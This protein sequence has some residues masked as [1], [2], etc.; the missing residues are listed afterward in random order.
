MFKKKNTFFFYQIFTLRKFFFK[1]EKKEESKSNSLIFHEDT[2]ELSAILMAEVP[3]CGDS[4]SILSSL[5]SGSASNR[6]DLL[7]KI[8][9]IYSRLIKKFLYMGAEATY[10]WVCA[11]VG[12]QSRDRLTLTYGHP[13]SLCERCQVPK[14]VYSSQLQEI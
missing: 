11:H 9:A 5:Q 6:R 4:F 3:V 2:V 12:Y 10:T 8:I 13:L 7:F 1:G 14:T